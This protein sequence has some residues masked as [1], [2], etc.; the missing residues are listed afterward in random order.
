ME[1]SMERSRGR[2]LNPSGLET[3][4]RMG[5]SWGKLDLDTDAMGL[6]QGILRLARG[7]YAIFLDQGVV[8]MCQPASLRQRWF[9]SVVSPY[10]GVALLPR[11]ASSMWRRFPN[12]LTAHLTSIDLL[13]RPSLN[14]VL[15]R[16]LLL[17]RY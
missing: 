14:L 7:R 8:L 1:I 15:Q 11:G 3:I 6:Q 2:H 12:R 17:Q 4:S 16:R 13:H 9:R 5:Q 10:K